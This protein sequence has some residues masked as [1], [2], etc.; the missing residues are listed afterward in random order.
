MQT[1]KYLGLAVF[2]LCFAFC[3]SLLAVS[4]TWNFTGNA[5]SNCPNES[6]RRSCGDPGNSMSFQATSGTTTVT[7]AVTAWYVNGSTLQSATLGQ[8]ANGLGD[9]YGGETCTKSNQAVGNAGDDEFLL[10][11]FS[12]PV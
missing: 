11:Q 10:F 12:A 9:C 3:P 2:S 1:S 5:G 6:G 8:Y 4:Y 7:V